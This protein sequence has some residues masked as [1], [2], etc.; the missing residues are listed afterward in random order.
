MLMV[1][2]A[3]NVR[4]L[5]PLPSATVACYLLDLRHYAASLPHVVVCDPTLQRLLGAPS[6]AGLHDNARL[7]SYP[8]HC[9]L[10]SV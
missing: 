3:R 2:V 5:P 7:A 9:S 6:H 1:I 10:S 8:Q 4:L